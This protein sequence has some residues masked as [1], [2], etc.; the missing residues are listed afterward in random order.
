M[1]PCSLGPTVPREP[2]EGYHTVKVA[3]DVD[4]QTGRVNGMVFAKQFI[5]TEAA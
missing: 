2:T 3:T 5:S 1:T 4:G